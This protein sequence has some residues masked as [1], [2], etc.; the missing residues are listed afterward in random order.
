[1]ILRKIQSFTKWT[2]DA[3]GSRL[4]FYTHTAGSSSNIT[5]SES[6]LS[7]IVQPDNADALKEIGEI[8]AQVQRRVGQPVPQRA[9]TVEPGGSL[10]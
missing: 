7:V 8:R 3:H 1:M 6:L 5:P 9:P 2:A 4:S 10:T